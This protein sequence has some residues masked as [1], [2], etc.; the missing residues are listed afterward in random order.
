M[1]HWILF[2]KYMLLVATMQDLILFFNLAE[3]RIASEVSSKEYILS[4]KVIQVSS[5]LLNILILDYLTCSRYNLMQT[6]KQ[7]QQT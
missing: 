5:C 2:F 1:A 6:N 4:K 3:E 7:Q